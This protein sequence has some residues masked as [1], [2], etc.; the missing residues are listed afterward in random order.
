MQ[1]LSGQ[2]IKGYK[3]IARWGREH[4]GLFTELTNPR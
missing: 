3:L 4:M 2:S 1:D